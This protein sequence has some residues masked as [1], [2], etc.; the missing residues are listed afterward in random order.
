MC[1]EKLWGMGGEIGWVG[2]VGNGAEGWLEEAEGPVAV[3][4]IDAS[5]KA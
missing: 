4:P 5:I 2:G 3:Q 1:K